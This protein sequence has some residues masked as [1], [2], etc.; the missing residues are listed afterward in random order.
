[1]F[2]YQVHFDLVIIIINVVVVVVN[3]IVI[4]III[5][6]YYTTADSFPFAELIIELTLYLLI[7]QIEHFEHTHTH[8][9]TK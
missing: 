9:H 4:V 1:M 7:Q 3:I 2:V 8:T 6:R 5:I